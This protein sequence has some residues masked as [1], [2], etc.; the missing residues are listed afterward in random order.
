MKIY[1]ISIV[2]DE[3]TGWNHYSCYWGVLKGEYS[4]DGVIKKHMNKKEFESMVLIAYN[5][6][7][8]K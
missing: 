1:N 6:S 8:I 7:L 4:T 2:K 5:D 3:L